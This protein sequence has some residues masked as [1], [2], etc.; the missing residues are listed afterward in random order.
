MKQK[1]LLSRVLLTI[2]FLLTSQFLL[3]Q[4]VTTSGMNGRVIDDQGAELPGATVIAIHAST[5][6]KYGSVTD[7]SGFY[8][9]PNMKA[10]GPYNITVSFVGFEN[11]IKEGVYLTLGQT[12]KLDAA[13]S[14]GATELLEVV[15]TAGEGEIFDGNRNG[16]STTVSEQQLNM[17]PNASRSLNDFT[18][19]TPQAAFT[20]TGGLSIAGS[21]NRYNSIFIDGAISN[22]AFGLAGNGQN[23]GQIGGLSMISMDA[24]EQVQVAVSPYDVTQSGFTGGSISAVTRSG[25][26]SFEGSVYYLIRNEKLAGKTPGF[27]EVDGEDREKLPE[28]SAKT[29]GLRLGG[30]IIKDKLFFFVN[31]EIQK[32]ETPSPF[33]FG[34]YTGSVSR[35]DIVDLVDYTKATYG[36][37]PGSFEDVVQKLEAEKILVKLDY[38]ISDAHKLT[39]RH[40]YNKGENFSPSNSTSSRVR[41]ANGGVFF[42][43]TTNSTALELNSSWGDK[44]N[45]L[46]IGRTTVEDNRDPL[47]ARFPY[48]DI[49]EGDIEFGSEEFSTGNFL[50][51]TIWT[52]TDNFNLYKGKHTFTFGTHNEFYDMNNVFVRQNFGSYDFNTIQDYYDGNPSAYFR[53]YSLVDNVTGDGTAAAA[54]FK[55]MQLGFY[56]QDEIQVNNQLRVT[57]GIRLDIPMFLDDPIDDGYFNT[58]A[59]PLIEAAGYD[60]KGAKAGQ[61]PD[62]QLLIS[63]RIG[64]NYDVNGDQSTQLRAGLGVFTSRIPFVWPGAMFNN[65]GATVGGTAQFSGLTF[66]GNPDTQP[67]EGD[68]GGNDAIPQG[69]MDLFASDFKFPQVFRASVGIDQKLPWWGLIGSAEVIYTKTINNVF[70]ENVNLA[71][72]TENFGGADNRALFTNGSIDGSYSD[73]YL[74]SNT[75]EGST[76][77]ITL[78][79]QKPFDNG[80]TANVAYNY[81]TAK[82]IFEGTSSQNSSQWRGVYAINGR[83]NAQN[84]RSDFDAGSRILASV[85]YRKEYAGFLASTISVFYNGQSGSPFSYTYNSGRFTGENSRERALI[86]VPAN[87]SQIVFD[88]SDRSA[89]E[90][91]A[92]LDA[93]I[94]NDDY[95][96]NRRGRYAEKNEARTP[97]SNI[98]DVKFMQ[99]F[100]LEMA[101]GKKNTIQVSFD[102]FNFTNFLNKDWGKRWQVPNGDGTSIQL[103]NYET[104]ITSPGGETIPT[105]SFNEG[106]ENK[107]DLLTKDDSGLISSRWQMQLGV[108]YIFGN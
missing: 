32:D 34:T 94:S 33:N 37:D 96:K 7:A 81:G 39:L 30:P 41:F 70:Y 77:N 48:V 84:G 8:R 97:F 14:S 43:S 9:I 108:R 78:S 107:E 51:Q 101:N 76:T 69:Q 24:L 88:E 47:G 38:N 27:L 98:I 102:I 23:G 29:Y 64:L 49:T 80:L 56:A 74:G 12:H 45:K 57:G 82:A 95:L 16:A 5:G 106:I 59:A 68:F 36:Y 2:G 22:D 67:T 89:A 91:W 62:P 79:L 60:L 54:A 35:A 104:N 4:G 87:Q 6:S 55:A 65:N 1:N 21:N 17:M 20:S 40:S 72:S 92:D 3:A 15:V 52:I 31:G 93:Y 28:F 85:S 10:G 42:P 86:F 50:E 99:E 73:V 25:T 13:L 90:Q 100:Y 75:S 58:T 105:F 71:P 66:N 53:S 61:A 83:N 18:R 26:N 103:L 19:L 11:Y 63:P 46:V 44:S